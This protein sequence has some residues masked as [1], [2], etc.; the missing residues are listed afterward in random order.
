MEEIWKD[1]QGYEGLYQV[2]N[3]GRVKSLHKGE[4]I[5]TLGR[6][7]RGYSGITLYKHGKLQPFS[8]HRLVA[9]AFIPNPH[10][11][12]MVNHKDEC[13]TNNNVE[14]LE[15]CD[16]LY[17]SRYG[18]CRKKISAALLGKHNYSAMK[19]VKCI[20]KDGI[21]IVY[22]CLTDAAKAINRTTT[23][24]SYAARHGTPSNGYRLI[25]L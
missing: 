13:R 11:L 5:L 2:S 7:T 3:Y 25:Y 6:T 24:A 8:V 21:E 9:M 22:Q 1:I 23:T 17:N 10:N 14:N 19:K 20:S 18:N 4:R 12:P 16:S 15:W